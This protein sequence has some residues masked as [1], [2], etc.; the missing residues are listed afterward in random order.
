MTSLP[1]NTSCN[2]NVTCSTMMPF[3]MAMTWLYATIFV[4]GLPGNILVILTIIRVKQLRNV[5]NG[6]I[7]NL[8]VS[9]LINI[10]WCLPTSLVS[11]Y[12]PW[13]YGRFV[14]K[15]IFPISDV[16]IANTIFTMM[17][18]TVDRYRAICYPFSRKVSFKTTLYIIIVTWIF[19][20]ICFGLPLV[21]SFEISSGYWVKKSCNLNLKNAEKIAHRILLFVILFII[22][23]IVVLFCILHM[24][25]G[26]SN[27]LKLTNG[28][29]GKMQLVYR[30]QKNKKILKVLLI[31]FSSFTFCIFPIQVLLIDN[32]FKGPISKW[33]YASIVYQIAIALLFFNSIMN[34]IILYALSTDFR[35]GYRKLLIC[36]TDKRGNNEKVEQKNFKK[37]LPLVPPF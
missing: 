28:S 8:A 14:C 35:Q 30:T 1:I 26:L 24:R 29:L 16:V 12:V 5:R 33:K 10:L 23:F 6:F 19:S 20:Y 31:I 13:P 4:V 11:L 34:P 36:F 15:Y 9:D 25:R 17:Q 2:S 37:M 22:P 32:V 3:K 18:I 7:A 27:M 21:G